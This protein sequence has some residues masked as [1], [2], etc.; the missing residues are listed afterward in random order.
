[1][2]DLPL[3]LPDIREQGGYPPEP[4]W[5]GMRLSFVEMLNW[6]TFDKHV[7]QLDLDGENA[8]VTGDIGSGK[9][10][11][12][13][14]ITTL[15]VPA[16]KIA[17]NKAAGARTRERDLRSYV[18]GYFK[19]E[20]GD[21]ALSAKSVGL[22]DP[23]HAY[24]VLLGRFE[25]TAY[26]EIITL[27]QIF[28]F[29][30]P[31]GQPERFYVLAD[32]ALSIKQDF[33]GFGQNIATLR[34]R[35]KK[36]KNVELF[37][38]FPPY[39]A[40]F[41]RRFSIKSEQ[42]LDLFL[43][44]V[45]MKQVGDLTEFVRNHMLEPFAV[46]KRISD[47]LAHFA[48]LSTAHNA[49]LKARD[50]IKRLE[51]IIDN[52]NNFEETEAAR[53]QHQTLRETLRAYFAGLKGAL[54][55]Q[56]IDKYDTELMQLVQR[57]DTLLATVREREGERDVIRQA[58]DQNGG[59]HI[60]ALEREINSKTAL[61]DQCQR[62]A[63]QYANPARK[64]GF[65]LPRDAQGF[66]ANQTSI[67]KALEQDTLQGNDFQN[68]L[69]EQE[70]QFRQ[71]KDEQEQIEAEID[72]LKSRRSNIPRHMLE[73]RARLTQALSIKEDELPFAGEL[74][75]VRKEEMPWE[76]AAERLVRSFA[77]SLLVPEHHY[78]ALS[79][80]V[81][82]THLRARLVYYKV[83]ANPPTNRHRSPANAL[84]AKLRIK[85]NSAFFGW[86]AR[87][88][89]R[90]FDHVCCDSLE[91]FHRMGKAVTQQGQIKSKNNRHEKDDRTAIDDRTR[92]VLGWSNEAKLAA[93]LIKAKSK[94][95]QA[96]RLAI[97]IN[98]LQGER[99]T[100]K[101]RND[102]LQKL[103]AFQSFADLDW[104]SIRVEIE[105]LEKERRELAEGSDILKKL[106]A[107][108]ETTQTSLLKAQ[109]QLEQK[110]RRSAQ[111]EERRRNALEQRQQAA[112]SLNEIPPEERPELFEE[113]DSLLSKQ[114]KDVTLN[115]KN[116]DARERE[117]RG[118]M[119]AQID[120]LNAQIRRLR[121]KIIKIMSDY[122]HNYPEE[123][124]E[125]DATPEAAHEYNEMLSALSG[126][127][128]PRFEQRFKSLL[129]ENAIREI[130]NF[131]SNLRVEAA[132]IKERIGTI[133]ESMREIDY[134]PGR[135]IALNAEPSLDAEIRDFQQDLRKCTQD[136]LSGS[137]DSAYS[138]SKFLEVKRIMERFRGREGETDH[139]KRWTRKVSDVRNWFVFSASE[140]YRADDAEHEHYSDSGGKS[141]GQKEKLA[142][143]VLAAS[144]AYQF[145]IERGAPHSRAF[146]FVMI[147]E[148]FGRGS[149]ES[150]EFALELFQ[151]MGLQLL[152]VTPMQK[153]HVIEP[154]IARVGFVHNENGQ[155]SMLRNLTIEDYHKEQQRH[156]KNRTGKSS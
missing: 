100:L 24:C 147:D 89:D 37:D 78:N 51:P 22:R 26:N 129:N 14:A 56:H 87:E 108:L 25:N 44:T 115:L 66:I 80:W 77:L 156:R 36:H 145:G 64:L 50:Q 114:L 5:P 38:S 28:H 120:K 6:G 12:V 137:K 75:K 150:A 68:E 47:M 95:Q 41:R 143:T 135:Y 126:D 122:A 155:R 85:D 127:D 48:D 124:R 17:Y 81:D 83:P 140:R 61:A 9:S 146:H 96:Q 2:N 4:T 21:P 1:M 107:Q 72:A 99:D 7:W 49:V 67:K 101:T 33:S 63:D 53:R 19:A 35:L 131:N 34:R 138:E 15:L 139:D 110:R 43:Q 136:T 109:T 103:S 119:N 121:E 152:I 133:N 111:L 60:S 11:L 88:I 153:I 142:Y 55:D 82:Q 94:A 70:I 149:D 39:G 29:R 84:A 106:K 102:L 32:G 105:R 52:C 65:G 97:K 132:Q 86:L 62:R 128:L 116:C 125:V 93:F 59:D 91:M 90:R 154:F 57:I 113:L 112:K 123:T 134:N 27:A 79:Q 42:A 40:A 69:I 148:A 73:I 16:Q 144:L 74:I 8:L 13:D 3:P 10:T 58:I 30:E 54:L 141:G 31:S 117:M 18:L 20:R 98:Q 130:A 104:R 76:G 92:Y 71:I 45:S 46:E 118:H 23:A 151:K